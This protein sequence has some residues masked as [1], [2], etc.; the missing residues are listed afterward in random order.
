MVFTDWHFQVELL[1]F[2]R[3][4]TFPLKELMMKRTLMMVT[5]LCACSLAAATVRAEAPIGQGVYMNFCASC[6][7][8]GIAGAPKTGDS[9]TWTARLQQGRE[10][11]V[12]HAIKG[13]Q[14]KQG[15][16]PAKG[17]NSALTDDEVVAAVDYMLAQSH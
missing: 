17:G 10:V 8:S 15:F 13:Y 9:A 16:M 5:L 4:P 11:L 1:R 14:G 3:Q 7:A 6:H 2:F 12:E